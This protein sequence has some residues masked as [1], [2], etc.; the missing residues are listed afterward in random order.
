M[1]G[2][3]DKATFVTDIML[4]RSF[5]HIDGVGEATERQIW[6]AGISGWNAFASGAARAALRRMVNLKPLME[7]AYRELSNLCRI[8]PES[9]IAK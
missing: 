2:G 9:Q 4:Q 8:I 5:I 7:L 6:N 3:I 1:R